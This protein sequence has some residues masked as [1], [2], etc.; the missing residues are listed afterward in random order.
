M[1]S[2]NAAFNPGSKGLPPSFLP[3]FPPFDPDNLFALNILIYQDSNVFL[4]LPCVLV[5][6]AG[7]SFARKAARGGM[8]I[9]VGSAGHVH[10]V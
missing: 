1:F 7:S 5:S 4:I 10:K 9:L 2:H 8:R 6:I 3:S